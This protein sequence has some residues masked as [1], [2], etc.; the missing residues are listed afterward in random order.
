MKKEAHASACASF[1]GGSR[2]RTGDPMLAKHMLYQ[3]SYTPSIIG[4]YAA[5]KPLAAFPAPRLCYPQS[6]APAGRLMPTCQ[7]NPL[8]PFRLHD[9]ATRKVPPRPVG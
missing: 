9:F 7:Q 8:R 4:G 6:P 2:I 3:L 1:C 5:P